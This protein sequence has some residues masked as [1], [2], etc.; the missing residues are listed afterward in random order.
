MDKKKHILQLI[1]QNPYISQQELAKEVKLSRSAAAGY[2]SNLMREG[3][4]LGKAYVLKE[5]SSVCCLGGANIDRKLRVNNFVMGD[6]NPAAGKESIGGTAR[7]IALNLSFLSI[8][9]SLFTLVGN[10]SEGEKILNEQGIDLSLIQ[11]IS[12]HKTGTYTAVLNEKNEM[13][14]A[15]ADMALYDSFL[16]EILESRR[17][18]LRSFDMLVADTNLPEESLSWLIRHKKKDQRLAVV[19][20]SAAKMNRLPEKL[21]GIDLLV[22]N[23]K[24]AEKLAGRYERN[25]K[26][27]EQ[28]IEILQQQGIDRIAITC[29]AEGVLV[30]EKENIKFIQAPRAEVADVTG[31]GDAFASVIIA[32]VLKDDSLFQACERALA[33]AKATIESLETV[34]RTG[35]GQ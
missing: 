3:E 17:N 21:A 10:D 15:L 31:A 30:A 1:R 23:I 29:G 11:R 26:D 28:I 5:N 33:R 12:S 7:N 4:I 27:K 24:E 22:L 34:I 25:I 20:V 6:S 9:T 19:P 32:A 2:I 14:L 13:I 35:K 16:P 18:R 8:D